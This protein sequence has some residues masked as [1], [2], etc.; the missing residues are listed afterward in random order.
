PGRK[1]GALLLLLLLW[2]D[3]LHAAPASLCDRLDS[4]LPGRRCSEVP[5]VGRPSLPPPAPA[6]PWPAAGTA[7][8]IAAAILVGAVALRT[9][10]ASRGPGEPDGTGKESPAAGGRGVR[11]AN[12]PPG[13]GIPGMMADTR[14][15]PAE[16][17]AGEAKE[18]YGRA[19]GAPG[20]EKGDDRMKKLSALV[21]GGALALAGSAQCG[22][23]NEEAAKIIA[24]IQARQA[25]KAEAAAKVTQKRLYETEQGQYGR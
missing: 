15:A 21:L 1:V 11:Q 6:I 19:R 22:E 17:A 14:I 7:A 12:L 24:E 8:A 20:G 13:N 18:E 5:A 2:E 23:P 3:G 10:F 4:S 9:G 25:A 16:G